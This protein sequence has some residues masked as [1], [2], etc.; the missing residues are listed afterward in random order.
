MAAGNLLHRR[1]LKVFALVVIIALAAGVYLQGDAGFEGVPSTGPGDSY[2]V[3]C[4]ANIT[5]LC[6]NVSQQYDANV[7]IDR[8]TEYTTA[9]ARVYYL[10]VDSSR[11]INETGN[12]TGVL[13]YDTLDEQFQGF[14]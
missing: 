10:R 11:V 4:P 7:S 6:Q 14:E 5:G 13:I 12:R 2:T 9:D 8:I 3:D 1:G